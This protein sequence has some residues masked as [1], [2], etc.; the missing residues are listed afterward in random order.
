MKSLSISAIITFHNEGL[1]ATKTLLGLERVRKFSEAR[2]ISVEFVAVL[3]SADEETTRVIKTNSVLRKSDQIIK[4]NNKDLGA[5]RNSGITLARGAYIAIF[6]G[7]DYYSENWLYKA[8]SVI[9]QKGEKVI[10]HPEFTISFGVTHAVG[11]VWDMEDRKDYLLSNCFSINPWPSCSFGNRVIYLSH[12][13]CRTD[14]RQ[15]GFGYEDWHWNLELVSNGICHVTAKDTALFYRRKT[16]SMLADMAAKGVII[17]P[18]NFFNRTDNW[19]LDFE[20]VFE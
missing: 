15:T 3:D 6:D 5:S 1:L 17:R 9:Q 12:P 10:V 4:V 18:S 14:A 20:K 16:E 8:L 7:D 11:D 2:G 13:Y 19:Q